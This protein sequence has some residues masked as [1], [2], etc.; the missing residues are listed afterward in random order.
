V[1][2]GKKYQPEDFLRVFIARKWLFIVPFVTVAFTTAVIVYM[3]PDRYQ[4]KATIQ[5]QAARVNSDL[6]KSNPRP[7][8]DARLTNLQSRV[9]TRTKLEN[10]IVQF[11][12][13]PD[14]RRS[15]LMEDVVERMNRD[16]SVGETRG[17]TFK[18]SFD[19]EN[20]VTAMRV[21]Q[22][23]AQLFIDES[24]IDRQVFTEGNVQFIDSQ[25]EETRQRLVEHEKRLEEYRRL[26]AGELPSQQTSNLT[27]ASNAQIQLQSVNDMLSRDRDRVQALERE[28]NELLTQ[29][30]TGPLPSVVDA[31]NGGG[32]A[33]QQLEAARRSLRQMELRLKPEHP[34]IIRAKRIIADLEQKAE[35]EALQM[36]VSTAGGSS[37]AERARQER[38]KDLKNNL[39]ALRTQIARREKD[40]DALRE[41]LSRYQS[42][43]EAAPSRETELI[44][45]NRDYDT[46]RGLYADLLKKSQESQM[47][48]ALQRAEI[49]EKFALL[50]PARAPERPISPN[51]GQ[52]NL[53][54]IFGGVA[55][56]LAFVALAEYRDTTFKSDDDILT[57]LSLPVLAMIPN[58][59]TRTERRHR[60]R[61]RVLMSVT[62]VLVA[63]V[64]AATA[65]WFVLHA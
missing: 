64:V 60:R 12:L 23:L 8:L 50:E 29:E 38:L 25:L 53:L 9:L 24:Y 55:L 26:H 52:L 30:T 7:S 14:L 22:R 13:Y 34:D 3:L 40:A 37:P 61:R 45:L 18:V 32:T 20:R 33:A 58:M 57:S 56:G 54:G 15:E 19:A 28:Q 21:T 44:G 62:A 35:A 65:V 46:M 17:N 4:S 6:I 39:D 51:R 59:V 63:L 36:P 43:A 1:I 48:A 10:L 2:P 47:A 41:M 16:I 42:R 31:E 11:D 5:I 27:A 49:G